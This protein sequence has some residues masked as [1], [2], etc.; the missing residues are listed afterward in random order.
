M[1]ISD[2]IKELQSL[3]ELYGDVDVYYRMHGSLYSPDF[4]HIVIN[5][6]SGE[7]WIVVE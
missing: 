1:Q 4:T 3:E 7:R 2:F 5:P 6:N